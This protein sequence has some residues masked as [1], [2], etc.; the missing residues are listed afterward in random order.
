MGANLGN[1]TQEAEKCKVNFY[2]G[3]S[4]STRSAIQ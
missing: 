4:R 3:T 2:D 1:Y